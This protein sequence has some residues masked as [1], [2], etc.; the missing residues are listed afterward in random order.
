M[1][2]G[3]SEGSRRLGAGRNRTLLPSPRPRLPLQRHGR[4]KVRT[5]SLAKYLQNGGTFAVSYAQARRAGGGCR[6]GAV[7]LALIIRP[8]ETV[9]GGSWRT[10]TTSR[11]PETCV[12]RFRRQEAIPHSPSGGGSRNAVVGDDPPGRRGGPFG[13]GSRIRG[14]RGTEP[15]SAGPRSRKILGIWGG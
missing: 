3:G 10:G 5:S 6:T 11:T 9:G 1:R 8:L 12:C 2:G 4:P 14:C 13:K 7:R 15:P